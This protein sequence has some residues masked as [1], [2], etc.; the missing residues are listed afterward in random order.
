MISLRPFTLRDAP[1][2]QQKQYPEM[3]MEEI[4]EM[5]EEWKT[6]FFQGKLFEM[7]AVT[8]DGTVVGSVSLYEQ[9]KSIVS[10]GIEIYPDERRK[11]YAS[12]GMRLIMDRARTLGYRI[13]QDQVRADNSA[14]IALH[15]SI[16]FETDG[17]DFTHAKGRNVLLWLC[18]L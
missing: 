3:S 10:V 6:G 5:I 1:A 7:R 9:T 4:R 18:C 14:G 2:I 12:A 11:G 8:V 15:Q 16:G 13:V 17:Y